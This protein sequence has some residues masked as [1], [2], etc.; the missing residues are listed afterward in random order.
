MRQYLAGRLPNTPDN[1]A[2]WIQHPQSISPGNVMP[3]LGVGDA[4]ARD[5]VAYLY[6]RRSN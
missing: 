1:M 4:E 2:R 3:E 5:I 6:S